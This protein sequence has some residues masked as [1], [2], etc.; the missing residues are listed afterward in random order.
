MS[1]LVVG[2]TGSIG[3]G[4]SYAANWMRARGIAVFDADAE[5][6][7]L[8]AGEA[9]AL[10]EAAFPGTASDGQVDRTRLSAAL[11]ADPTAFKRL[12]TIVH[13]LVQAAE[14]AFLHR[15]AQSGAAL[16]VLEIPLLF[17]T[18]ADAIIDAV[19]VVSAPAAAQ[20]ERVLARPGMTPEKLAVILARQIPD[21]EKRRRAE[22]VV[23]TGGSML[24]T[25]AALQAVFDS[26][27]GRT[28][29]AFAG[30]WL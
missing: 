19:I 20:R 6:H 22:F 29:K 28:G 14:R 8:Y 12:E 9:V 21:A 13:P 1:L 30:H 5:V 26:L 2:L 24:A 3:M 11:L 27:A 15:A 23:D 10:I 25:D 18:G 4:K 17:E 7:R 16:A